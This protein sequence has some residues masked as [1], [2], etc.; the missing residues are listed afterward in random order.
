[1]GRAIVPNA[2]PLGD[3]QVKPLLGRLK[4]L[5][6]RQILLEGALFHKRFSA[7]SLLWIGAIHVVVLSAV[8]Y[9]LGDD[10][11]GCVRVVSCAVLACRA[12]RRVSRATGVCACTLRSSTVPE[13]ARA[14]QRSGQDPC[15]G[16][17]VAAAPACVRLAWR[18]LTCVLLLCFA[19]RCA[20]VCTSLAP[21]VWPPTLRSSKTPSAHPPDRRSPPPEGRSENLHILAGMHTKCI[22]YDRTPPLIEKKQQQQQRQQ[23]Q[24]QHPSFVREN[25][26]AAHS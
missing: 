13:L 11:A 24:Q 6:P 26:H 5:S 8:Y 14:R 3:S 7:A 20:R 9:A 15:S 25:Q 22:I 21:A 12:G 1:V 16:A 2:A 19:G 23:P 10:D 18:L 17:A 4:A